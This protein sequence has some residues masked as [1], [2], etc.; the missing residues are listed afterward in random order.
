MAQTEKSK[1][2]ATRGKLITNAALRCQ[3]NFISYQITQGLGLGLRLRL[4]L[5]LGTHNDDVTNGKPN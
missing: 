1:T 3:P 5:G 2:K 4:G